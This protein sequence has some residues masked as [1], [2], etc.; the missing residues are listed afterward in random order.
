MSPKGHIGLVIAF[1]GV[2]CA[3]C[4]SSDALAPEAACGTSAL[5]G[6]YGSQRNGQSSPGT[7]FTEVGIATLDGHGNI[8]DDQTVSIN[9]AFSTRHVVGTYAIGADCK[10]TAFDSAGAVVAALVMAHGGDEV[11]GMSLIAGNNIPVHYER[12]IGT[13]S[14]ATLNGTYAFQRNGQTGPGATLLAI[15]LA[16]F[17]GH[18]NSVAEQTIDRSGSFNSVANQ[19]GPYTLNA[20]C[21]GTLVA[22]GT[23]FS[24]IVVVGGGDEILGM[25]LT[26]GNNVVTHY[27]RIK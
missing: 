24:Q 2:L 4:G 5:A 3:A 1:A 25:S 23:P 7:S 19:T 10:G 14:L 16:S 27:E 8:V 6:S 22:N 13:C 15:G 21:S 9:G 12:I 26:P 11:L 20:D 17:D 18:G